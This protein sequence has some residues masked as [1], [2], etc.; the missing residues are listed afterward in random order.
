MG[1]HLTLTV[2]LQ[3]G[4]VQQ[5]KG[6]THFWIIL[7]RTVKTNSEVVQTLRTFYTFL[8][9]V[10]YSNEKKKA[11]Q[12]F[13]NYLRIDTT[14]KPPLSFHWTVY[15]KQDPPHF[16]P[17][18]TALCSSRYIAASSTGKLKSSSATSLP[19]DT[20]VHHLNQY[21]LYYPPLASALNPVTLTVQYIQQVC[22]VPLCKPPMGIH[23]IASK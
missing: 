2:L 11:D 7:I 18:A 13:Q 12:T 6:D 8:V 10:S 1:H 19:P 21:P 23:R 4:S 9:M 22:T 5:W 15:F 20:T 14:S 16:P 17:L 3:H